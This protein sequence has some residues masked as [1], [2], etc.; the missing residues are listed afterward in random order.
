MSEELEKIVDDFKTALK[1]WH[2]H[3]HAGFCEHGLY[4]C[5]FS[6]SELD[7]IG[8]LTSRFSDSLNDCCLLSREFLHLRSRRQR[9]ILKTA[10][11][12]LMQLS[13]TVSSGQRRITT[14]IDKLV[15]SFDHM[16]KASR[17]FLEH[18]GTFNKLVGS[19]KK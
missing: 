10:K 4:P 7:K 6:G 8:R 5:E 19:R 12:R 18:V 14:P 17:E 16:V 13:R 2:S 15:K 11:S 3:Q 1:L 9:I